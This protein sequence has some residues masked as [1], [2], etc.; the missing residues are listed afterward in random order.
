MMRGSKQ[1]NA[2]CLV[3]WK[4]LDHLLGGYLARERDVIMRY[5]RLNQRSVVLR[6]AQRQH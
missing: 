3:V 2:A 4:T 6:A 5:R 1:L